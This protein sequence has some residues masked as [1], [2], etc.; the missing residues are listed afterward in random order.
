MSRPTHRRFLPRFFATALC[1]AA[2]GALTACTTPR[3]PSTT[4]EVAA[5]S[6]AFCNITDERWAH[7]NE[8][9][10]QGTC[11]A[12]NKSIFVPAY[13]GS[14]ANAVTF[15]QDLMNRPNCTGTAQPNNRVAYSAT[16]TGKVGDNRNDHCADTTR[17]TVIYETTTSKVITQ[18][19]G[20]P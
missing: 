19:P 20:D 6:T 11:S 17:G 3:A 7:I 1:L 14:K 5:C 12:N 16:F 13:C 8:R 18:F 9:H 15:C 2:L 4:P 10:C